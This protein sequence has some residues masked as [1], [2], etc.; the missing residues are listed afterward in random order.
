MMHD[1]TAI[2]AHGLIVQIVCC[3]M[4]HVHVGSVECSP[5]VCCL[6]W[7]IESIARLAGTL[8]CL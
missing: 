3:A 7:G 4:W 6:L 5:G 2:M 8:L 1:N